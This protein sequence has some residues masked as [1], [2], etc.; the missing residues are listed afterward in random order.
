MFSC[1][2]GEGGYGGESGREDGEL[3]WERGVLTFESIES[4]EWAEDVEGLEGGEEEEGEVQGDG[5]GLFGE[6]WRS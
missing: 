3:E 6:G 4:V 2:R 1:G 5:G